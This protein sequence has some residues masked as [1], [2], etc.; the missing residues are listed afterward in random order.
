[1][2]AAESGKYSC[3]LLEAERPSIPTSTGRPGGFLVNAESA[4][5]ARISAISGGILRGSALP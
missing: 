3:R 2:F 1:M 4:E 5:S